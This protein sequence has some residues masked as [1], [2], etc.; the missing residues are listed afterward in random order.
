MEDF[1]HMLGKW[2]IVSTCY[3]GLMHIKVQLHFMPMCMYYLVN[4]LVNCITN[5]MCSVWQ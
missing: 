5:C 3:G 2:R 1:K 4:Q